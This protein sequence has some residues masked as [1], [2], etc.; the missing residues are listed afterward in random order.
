MSKYGSN[1]DNQNGYKYFDLS[2]YSDVKYFKIKKEGAYA[3]DM[4]PFEISSKNNLL[5]I[6]KE[7]QMGELVPYL[8]FKL[9]KNIGPM[10]KAVVCPSSIGKPC[11]I[12]EEAQRWAKEKGYKSEEYKAL[13]ATDRI[14]FNMVDADDDDHELMLFEASDFLFL[15][16]LLDEAKAQADRKGMSIED[17]DFAGTA[18]PNNAKTINFRA[19]TEKGPTSEFFKYKAFSFEKRTNKYKDITPVPLDSCIMVNSYDELKAMLYGEDVAEDEPPARK[20]SRDDD[21]ERPAKS[22]ARDDDDDEAPRHKK[23]SRDEEEDKKPECPVSGLEFGVDT[24]E[25]R[26]CNNC[27]LYSECS[28]EYTRRKKAK[29]S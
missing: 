11:P 12:C 26:K 24:D 4:I 22:K 1:S 3:F 7:A 15:K 14:I 20:P 25:S 16:E 29:N 9:H 28:A 21:D 5:V 10:K 23:P 19:A 18:D 27:E 13:K 6:N 17:F 2:D 8:T